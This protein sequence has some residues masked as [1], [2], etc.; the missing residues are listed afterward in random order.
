MSALGD[1]AP[2]FGAGEPA[3]VLA[4]DGAACGCGFLTLPR[5]VGRWPETLICGSFF[6]FA[7]G[8][9]GAG[10]VA[11]GCAV[12]GSP[13]GAA[14]CAPAGRLTASMT[15]TMAEVEMRKKENAEMRP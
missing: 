7:R 3:S 4:A 11:A 9:V 2:G 1:T 15:V 8:W 14:V 5:L 12:A 13:D 10:P 6:W